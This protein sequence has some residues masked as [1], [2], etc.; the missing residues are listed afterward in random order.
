MDALV[1]EDG[2]CRGPEISLV[3]FSRHIT[4]DGAKSRSVLAG[5]DQF[6]E[7][8]S[9]ILAGEYQGSPLSL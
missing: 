1:T 4:D 5:A 3:S 6:L 7:H 9:C 8:S 2:G